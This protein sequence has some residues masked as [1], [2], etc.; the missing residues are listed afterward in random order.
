MTALTTLLQLKKQGE[1][2]SFEDILG[3]KNLLAVANGSLLSKIATTENNAVFIKKDLKDLPKEEVVDLIARS[4]VA[5]G[6]LERCRDDL[7]PEHFAVVVNKAWKWILK[8]SFGYVDENG[9]VRAVATAADVADLENLTM[10]G[11]HPHLQNVF[12]YL[13]YITDKV[14]DKIPDMHSAGKFSRRK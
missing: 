14:S 4:F 6:D 3:G 8:Y 10:D 13:S 5:K 9:K 12:P 7:K 2:I 11:L 1:S